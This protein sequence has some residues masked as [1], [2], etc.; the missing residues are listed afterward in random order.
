MKIQSLI[1][2]LIGILCIGLLPRA[3]AVVPPPDG[4]Y[5][6]FTTAEGTKALQSLTTGSANTAV[7]WYSLFSNA[8]GSFNTATGVGSLLFNT[9]DQNTAFGAAALLFNTT[10]INN[11][12]VGATALLNNTIAEENTATGAFAL[13]SNTEGD[14][15]T[16]TG[17]FALWVNTTGARNTA[18]GDS[19]MFSNTTGNQNT[20]TGNAALGFN[21]TGNGNTAVGAAA[22]LNND[23]GGANTGVGLNALLDNTTGFNNAALGDR[24]LSNNIDGPQNTA[25]GSSALFNNIGAA[26]NTGVGY[27]AL[28]LNTSG[29]A[30][31][32]VGFNALFA[33]TGSTNTA[34]GYGAGVNATTGSNN[35]YIGASV[36]GMAGED[37]H[38]Y[39]RNI[40]TT[41]VSGGG[42]DT[43][44]VNLATGLL[45][46]LSSSQRYKEDIKPMDRTSEALYR[47]KPV[48]YRYKK[49]IDSTQSPA[50]GLIAEEVADVNSALVARNSE[51]QPESVHYEMVNAMLLNEFLKEHRKNEEQE[52]TI[53]ELKSGMTALA[54]TVKEQAVQIQKMSAQ[55]AAASPSRGGLEASKPALPV[56][57]SPS[58]SV[59]AR[60]RFIF[61]GRSEVFYD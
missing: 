22:L 41:S 6:N 35:V 29:A 38:T 16:A 60:K 32:A 14:F 15:N 42:T 53:G 44:T 30:N 19:A 13:S 50:F 37:N 3:Q 25:V 52:N 11:T 59:C 8:A 28:F 1:H 12:A 43:V 9:A 49:E 34:L 48:S 18:T 26:A 45:G 7:G 58:S 20:A 61:R 31:T 23:T 10:G 55:L 5:P 2:I 46:H 24:A 36:E 27:D 51:G 54:A 21:I 4:G 39:I 47:L 33:T 57:S 17:A 56:S 40:N